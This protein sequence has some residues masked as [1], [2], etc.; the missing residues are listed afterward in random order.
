MSRDSVK[1]WLKKLDECGYIKRERVYDADGK[2]KPGW[3]IC[4]VPLDDRRT[5]AGQPQDD[6]KVT[7]V[8][9]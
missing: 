6:Q 2:R 3:M 7:G 9:K 8:K 1:G 4:I 5:T